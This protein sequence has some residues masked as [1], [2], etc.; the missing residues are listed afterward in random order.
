MKSGWLGGMATVLIVG[1]LVSSTQGSLV[2]NGRD[3]TLHPAARSEGD[4]IWVP[5][6]AF[7]PLI[8]IE[9]LERD[10]R[11]A[12][13]WN[14]GCGELADGES[15]E[16]SSVAYASLDGLVSRVGGSV[17]RAGDDVIVDVS[18]AQLT[19][20]VAGGEELT[21]RLDRFAPTLVTR[22]NGVDVVRFV[23]CRT[24]VGETTVVFGPGDVGRATLV[25]TEGSTCEVR[26]AFLEEA[27]LAVRR[28][29]TD[30]AYSVILVPSEASSIV[31]T[32][33]LGNGLSLFEGDVAVGE[34]SATVVYV[35]ADAWR[36][37]LDVR[38]VLPITG[39]GTQA[40]VDEA[41][42]AAGASVAISSR[43]GVEVGLVVI[44]GV[45]FS[46]DGDAS[47]ALGFDILGSL[48]ALAPEVAAFAATTSARIALDGVGR[49]VG[50][51]EL[52]GFPPGYAGSIARGFP[53]GFCV[54]RIRDG[55]VVSIL[56]EPYVVAD[57]SAALLVA[58]GA[59]RARLAGLALGDHVD[60]VCE[61]GP[62]RNFIEDALSIDGLLLWDGQPL[63]ASS[64]SATRWSVAGSDWQG[65]F[66]F[67][68]VSGDGELSSG[69]VLSLLALLPA[70]ARDV[71]VLERG[72]AAALALS[73]GSFRG[74]WGSDTA[75]SV[76][77]G[78]ILK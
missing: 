54:V 19:E 58:A 12:L 23:N 45:P 47:T 68:S 72:G 78:A 11:L 41:M 70:P 14:G 48:V 52:I 17:R 55:I 61:V 50:Y 32:T 5:V 30:G 10:G 25:A 46:L 60:L 56:D 34:A 7:A 16:I 53:D 26:V 9:P 27:A 42:A 40:P 76:S 65:G 62:E 1:A 38:P 2:I 57:P 69:D 63:P 59:A 13:R 4:S 18:V 33:A 21:V 6:L 3:I 51:D 29:E 49:P 37:R 64:G 28:V 75:V 20:L 77:L 73:V 43:S 8:G 74:R 15:R 31:S 24:D 44:G 66:F 67:L 22:S 36:S 71:A 39:S 35:R